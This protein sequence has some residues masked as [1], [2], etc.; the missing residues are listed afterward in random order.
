M[1]AREGEGTVGKQTG[2]NALL[3]AGCCLENMRC[4]DLL[5]WRAGHAA[6]A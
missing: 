5:D 6:A 2:T 4:L 1:L 3:A